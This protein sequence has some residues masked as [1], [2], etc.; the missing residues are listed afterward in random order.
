MSVSPLKF[1]T[2]TIEPDEDR[3]ERHFQGEGRIGYVVAVS[4]VAPFAMVALDQ[5][6][7]FE[8][9]SRSEPDIEPHIFGLDGRKTD[10]DDYY[11][12]L[13]DEAGFTVLKALRAEIV[14]VLEKYA[15]TVIPEGDLERPV[16]WLRAS[17]EVM[18]GEP[19]TVRDALFCRSV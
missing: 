12:G 6:E 16:R 1:A 13:V 14:R 17:E 8:N 19:I 15:V 11:R 7:V 2:E 9:G 5:M 3:I 10:P 4:I 18:V